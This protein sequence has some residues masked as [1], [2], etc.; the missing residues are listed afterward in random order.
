MIIDRREMRD[1]IAS[2][3]AMLMSGRDIAA[4]QIPLS[5]PLTKGEGEIQVDPEDAHH[6]D[7]ED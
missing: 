6:P 7:Q 2:V 5:S 1:K 4:Q 3:L